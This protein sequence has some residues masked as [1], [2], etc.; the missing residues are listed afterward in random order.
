MNQIL[1]L[2][3]FFVVVII[4]ALGSLIITVAQSDTSAIS[5]SIG[6]KFYWYGGVF[7]TRNNEGVDPNMYLYFFEEIR[8]DT[9]ILGR[10]YAVIFNSYLKS[11]RYERSDRRNV[12]EWINGSERKKFNMDVKALD[13]LESAL[14]TATQEN[15]IFWGK[16]VFRFAA[17]R[18]EDSPSYSFTKNDSTFVFRSVIENRVFGIFARKFGQVESSFSDRTGFPRYGIFLHAA[19]IDGQLYGDT[20]FGQPKSSIIS[21]DPL[22]NALAAPNPFSEQM[23]YSFQLYSATEVS[24]AVVSAS[25]QTVRSIPAQ[26]LASGKHTYTWDGKDN[27]GKTAPAGAYIVQVYA[28]DKPLAT[29]KV[30]KQ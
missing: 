13:T 4:L 12:Y 7:T 22:P 25:G 3:R 18:T 11:Q 26:A 2:T 28:N 15:N 21:N 14:T 24:V 23:Q 9:L 6:N 27:D 17:I 5:L 10:K 30:V 16:Y 8:K 29:A 19:R 20:L 1:F